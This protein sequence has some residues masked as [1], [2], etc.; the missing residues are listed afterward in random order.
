[1]A[2]SETEALRAINEKA[3]AVKLSVTDHPETI[4]TVGELLYVIDQ[5]GAK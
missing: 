5:V 4:Q 3:N 2:I 1:M